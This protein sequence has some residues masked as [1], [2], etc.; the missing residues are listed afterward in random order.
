MYRVWQ[1]PS[2]MFCL[3]S[4]FL[5]NSPHVLVERYMGP[6]A[7]SRSPDRD[8]LILRCFGRDA[9]ATYYIVSPFFAFGAPNNRT[10][11]GARAEVD[12][13]C[14]QVLRHCHNDQIAGLFRR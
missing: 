13:L 3:P 14:R 8:G 10:Q 5:A 1:Y 4:F 11:T 12:F 6:T 7:H 2:E 9:V